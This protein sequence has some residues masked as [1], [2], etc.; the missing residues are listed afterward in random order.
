VQKVK[1]THFVCEQLRNIVKLV[2]QSA[3]STFYSTWIFAIDYEMSLINGEVFNECNLNLMR[4][5]YL[6]AISIR[7]PSAKNDT[8]IFSRNTSEIIIVIS[9][10]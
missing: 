8:E 7:L 10:S 1:V 9:V 2:G 4:R 6:R 5:F 3:D